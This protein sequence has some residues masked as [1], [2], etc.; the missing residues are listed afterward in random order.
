MGQPQ[1]RQRAL[2]L[3]AVRLGDRRQLQLRA[4]LG[5]SFVDGKSG[6]IRGDLEE[7]T[8]GLFEIHGVE[9]LPVH[10]RRDA[11]PPGFDRRTLLQLTGVTGCSKCHV[12][13]R[14]HSAGPTPETRCASQVHHHSRSVCL[15]LK[16][17]QPLILA[18]GLKAQ[19]LGQKL[20]GAP[21][22]IFPD[23]CSLQA[24]NG[25]LGTDR[26]VVPGLL[27]A[28]NVARNQLQEETVGIGETQNLV[29]EAAARALV[30]NTLRQKS[31]DPEAERPRRYRQCHS[32]NLAAALPAAV[33]T[34][35][36]KKREQRAGTSDLVTVVEVIAAR[37]VEVHRELDEA[38]SQDTGVEVQVSLRIAGDGG[39]V[40]DCH[41]KSS[42]YLGKAGPA[43][44]PLR[45][46]AWAISSRS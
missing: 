24:A 27:G 40:M 34:R 10:H 2:D 11:E 13:N 20:C 26:T 8:S 5:R 33:R 45:P 38:K 30:L 32:G 28:G 44:A 41:S 12:V 4:E 29:V 15:G 35:P 36:G 43:P 42:G 22:T 23:G 39:D 19:H 17:Q 1:R 37:I 21:V 25:V 3:L 31:L 46:M 18:M 14:A 7:N 16:T 6:A 9:V